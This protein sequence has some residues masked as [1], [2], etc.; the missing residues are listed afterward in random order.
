VSSCCWG[1]RA[2]RIYFSAPLLLLLA[3][4]QVTLMPQLAVAQA[5][6][7]VVLAA[8]VCWAL[9]RG[10]SAGALS[11]FLAGIALDLLSGAPFGVHTF[12]TTLVGAAFVPSERSML[13]PSVALFCTIIQQAVYVWLLRAA[14]WPLQWSRVLLDVV[15][16]AALLNLVLTAL[17]YPLVSLLYRRIVPEEPGW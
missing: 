8:V 14:G 17:L 9:L 13:L 11:G 2:I 7:D 4:L 15:L 16:P 12:V 6:P 10:P 1:E 3:L 5:Q